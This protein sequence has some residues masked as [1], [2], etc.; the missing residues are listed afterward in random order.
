VDHISG[1]ESDGKPDNLA[2]ACHACNTAKGLL[3]ARLGIGRRT[4]QYNPRSGGAHNLAQ[5]LMAVMSIKGEGPWTVQQGVDMIRATPPADRS[6]YA[7][8]IWRRRRARGTAG[9][10][11]PV[12]ED[13]IPF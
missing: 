4:R 11:R 13:E 7:A 12:P 10:A 5:W 9:R 3:F 8:E 1:D 2:P 6:A